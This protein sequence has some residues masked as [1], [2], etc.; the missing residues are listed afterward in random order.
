MTR[1]KSFQWICGEENL[2]GG[3]EGR[4]FPQV[5]DLFNINRVLAASQGVGVAQGAL[6]LAVGHVKKRNCHVQEGAVRGGMHFFQPAPVMPLVEI[7]KTIATTPEILQTVLE[8]TRSLGIESK[9]DRWS[10]A[11]QG[12]SEDLPL[13]NREPGDG[14]TSSRPL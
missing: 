1:R 2:I 12:L 3:E 11:R 8:F 4:G 9:S 5:M 14:I 7:V 6:D 10:E 13:W